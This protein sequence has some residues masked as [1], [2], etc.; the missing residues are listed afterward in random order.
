MCTYIYENNVFC[1]MNRI[2]T[3]VNSSTSTSLWFPSLVGGFV[4]VFFFLSAAISAQS[5]LYLSV[6]A[7]DG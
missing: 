7:T 3:K 6:C 2:Y 1:T 4:F 5:G